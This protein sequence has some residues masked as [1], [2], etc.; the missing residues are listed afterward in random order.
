MIAP[1]CARSRAERRLGERSPDHL[2]SLTVVILFALTS[3][4][5][6]EGDLLELTSV[7]AAVRPASD[8]IAPDPR[9]IKGM[10]ARRS[11]YLQFGR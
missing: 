9:A 1:G 8:F 3:D 5:S 11:A 2:L 6:V 4:R 10:A 7:R